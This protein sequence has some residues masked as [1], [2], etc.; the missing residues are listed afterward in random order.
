[1][2]WKFCCTLNWLFKLSVKQQ[3]FLLG[4]LLRYDKW[5]NQINNN[6]IRDLYLFWGEYHI[7]YPFYDNKS[8][9]Y[10][11]MLSGLSKQKNKWIL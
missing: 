7:G 5:T 2:Q 3:H 11:H 4:L 6:R 9:I 1:M 10:I 8:L